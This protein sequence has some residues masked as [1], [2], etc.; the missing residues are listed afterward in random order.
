MYAERDAQFTQLNKDAMPEP[1]AAKPE[2]MVAT[3]KK[4]AGDNEEAAQPNKKTRK[5]D[6]EKSIGSVDMFSESFPDIDITAN[7]V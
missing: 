3:G 4:V 7:M 2:A 5:L 6:K 1:E